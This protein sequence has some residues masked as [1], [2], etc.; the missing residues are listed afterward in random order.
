[1]KPAERQRP[2]TYRIQ[3]Q[4][5]ASTFRKDVLAGLS[6]HPKTLPCRWL[7]DN[8]G[9]ELFEAITKLP[10]Y[11]PTR[12]ETSIL[13]ENAAAIARFAGDTQTLLEYGAGAGIK[14]E[15]LIAALHGLR[16]Y[17]PI[18]IADEFLAQTAARTAARFPSLEI[19]PI[20]SNFLVE[21]DIPPFLR[22]GRSLA[23]FPGSTI[24]NLD[25][26][27]AVAFLSR[28]RR[29]AGED[30]AAI[31]GVDLQKDTETLLAA[32]DDSRGVTED[33]NLNLLVRINRELEADFVPDLFAHSARWNVGESAVEMHLV[34][35]QDQVVTVDGCCFTFAEGE[36][37]HTESS[38]KYDSF[39]IHALARDSG[40]GVDEVWTDDAD[41]FAVLGLKPAK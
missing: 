18:D 40:W 6:V 22:R 41:Q 32:Y 31:V 36:T 23:F 17:V 12:V 10:E 35:L 1:M 29:H 30:G 3:S 38:R 25:P 34:S 7:Y 21:F 28:L 27:E 20:V 33:F 2:E 14:T 15:L 5:P 37:I 13:R 26:A 24:G 9:S 4:P 19:W 39:R 8:R 11:Y 16:Y